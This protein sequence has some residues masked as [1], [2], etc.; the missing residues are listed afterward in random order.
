MFMYGSK[1]ASE[2][3][4]EELRAMTKRVIKPDQNEIL[5]AVGTAALEIAHDI[6]NSLTIVSSSLELMELLFK[7]RREGIGD[8]ALSTLREMTAEVERM[9]ELLE[10]L[11]HV[12]R[13][14]KVHIEP[15]NLREIVTGIVRHGRLAARPNTITV[16]H[17]IPDNLPPVLGDK[18]KLARVLLNLCVNAFDA[19]PNGGKLMLRAY[20]ADERICLEIADTG[21]GIPENFD[22][23]RPFNTTKDKGWGL[24]LA[25]VSQIVQALNGTLSYESQPGEGTT[26]RICLPARPAHHPE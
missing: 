15:V 11:R 10:Q 14:A 13:P 1:A 17:Q 23:F 12:S 2:I 16:E 4:A 6:G 24:G 5:A 26:F 22:P 25:V 9:K 7:E 19:M 20:R 8:F 18:E 21:V 3:P